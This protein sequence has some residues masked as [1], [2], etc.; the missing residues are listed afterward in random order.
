MFLAAVSDATAKFKYF[1]IFMILFTILIFV[2]VVRLLMARQKNKFAIAF[3]IV[4]L[5]VFLYSDYA[6]VTGWFK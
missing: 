3:G 4:S 2:G 6:M 5:L 1:D